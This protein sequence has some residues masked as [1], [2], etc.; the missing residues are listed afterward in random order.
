MLDSETYDYNYKQIFWKIGINFGTHN[1]T[2]K[3]L[4]GIL[5]TNTVKKSPKN[6]PGEG[7]PV[8]DGLLVGDH[9]HVADDWITLHASFIA[10]LHV[11]IKRV[12]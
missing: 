12:M 5:E 4:V 8:D 1:S 11:C 6:V 3:Q 9:L 2:H 7:I 10:L